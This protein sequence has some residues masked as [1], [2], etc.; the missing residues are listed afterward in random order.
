MR[1]ASHVSRLL[2]VC[3]YK[4]LRQLDQRSEFASQWGQSVGFIE[5]MGTGEFAKGQMMV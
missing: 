5:D 1:W 3:L 4:L 2:S